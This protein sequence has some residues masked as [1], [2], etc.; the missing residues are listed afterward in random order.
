MADTNQLPGNYI[1]HV[2]GNM[3]NG[4]YIAGPG[5]HQPGCG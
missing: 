2:Q 5:L 4:Q 1:V 3:V